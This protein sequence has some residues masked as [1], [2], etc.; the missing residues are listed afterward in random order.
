M[1]SDRL[2]LNEHN[3][4][5][6]VAVMHCLGLTYPEAHA[7]LAAV[8]RKPRKGVVFR[9]VAQKL[10]LEPRPEFSHRAYKSI[11]PELAQGRFIVRHAHHVFA[12]IDG[13]PKD[14]RAPKPGL[15]VKMVYSP[16]AL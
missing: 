8:G 12:I 15:R 6:V 4:C 9:N 2:A 5:T 13:Q 11:L 10:G 1:N 14:W 16:K 7:R 3:D